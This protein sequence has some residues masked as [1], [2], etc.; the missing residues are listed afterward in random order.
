MNLQTIFI[1]NLDKLFGF[2]NVSDQKVYEIVKEHQFNSEWIDLNDKSYQTVDEIFLNNY[3]VFEEHI[4][5]SVLILGYA[6]CEA[7]LTD[8][9]KECILMNPK[10]MIPNGKKSNEEKNI[11][12]L[13][14][15]NANSKDDLIE[16]L[17]EKEIRN[18]MYK[19]ISEIVDYS[20]KKLNLKW[21]EIDVENLK[22]A[23]KI[24][25][26]IMHNNS[27]VDKSLSLITNENIGEPLKL[28]LKQIHDFGLTARK[29]SRLLWTQF[30]SSYLSKTEKFED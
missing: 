6:Y 24:R 2:L 29:I 23:N 14:F 15:L 3:N 11:S 7:F 16:I 12:Y 17:V 18:L 10:I 28:T 26:C 8:L 4:L 25:N 13:M 22:K 5:K 1:K 21:E 27:R 20:E 30:E 9:F 19:N